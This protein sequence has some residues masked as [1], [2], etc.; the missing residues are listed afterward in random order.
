M[1]SN[2]VGMVGWIINAPFN[3]NLY[4]QPWTYFLMVLRAAEPC[5]TFVETC[6]WVKGGPQ[7]LNLQV[8]SIGTWEKAM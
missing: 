7:P 4:I 2:D 6:N 5:Y 3:T 8:K 1:A